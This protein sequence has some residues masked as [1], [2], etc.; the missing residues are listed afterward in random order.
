MAGVL[1]DIM[2]WLHLVGV[3]VVSRDEILNNLL[4]LIS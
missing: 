1:P 3:R 2:H 4:L